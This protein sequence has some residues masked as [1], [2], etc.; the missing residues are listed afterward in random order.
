MD[1]DLHADAVGLRF[2]SYRKGRAETRDLVELIAEF[3]GTH[4]LYWR[5]RSGV[6]VEVTLRTNGAYSA[7]KRV[8]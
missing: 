2:T 3:D 7:I 5:N 8:I 4:G 6:S 1:S